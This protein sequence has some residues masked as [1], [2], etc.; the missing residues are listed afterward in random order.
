MARRSPF[1]TRRAHADGEHLGG[2][3]AAARQ[4]PASLH[5]R[6]GRDPGIDID[7]SLAEPADRPRRTAA[8]PPNVIADTLLHQAPASAGTDDVALLLIRRQDCRP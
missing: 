6:A 3:T 5:R 7:V 1:R 8:S 4:R 2:D